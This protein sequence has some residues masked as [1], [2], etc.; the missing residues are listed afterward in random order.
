MTIS[1]SKSGSSST[2]KVI[3]SR[4]GSPNSTRSHTEHRI[5][6]GLS[7]INSA[8]NNLIDKQM[9]PNE[10]H[11]APK[12]HSSREPDWRVGPGAPASSLHQHKHQSMRSEPNERHL[13][14][15]TTL[16]EHFTATHVLSMSRG[17]QRPDY[18][19]Q[20]PVES[21]ALSH[22]C[23]PS[24]RQS[25]VVDGNFRDSDS[26]LWRQSAISV[27]FCSDC[28]PSGCCHNDSELQAIGSARS[29]EEF[30]CF[31]IKNGAMHE[32]PTNRLTCK[33][34]NKSF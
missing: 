4:I 12:W 16:N 22:S 29:D 11:D 18:R 27:D 31:C 8:V 2:A 17:S 20:V 9:S 23:T 7:Q 21:V 6:S 25:T 32:S 3:Q 33:Q 1:N 13:A 30:V 34:K 19:D 5:A 15:V 24:R 14:S 28:C 10:H 26:S